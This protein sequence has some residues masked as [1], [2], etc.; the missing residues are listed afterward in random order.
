[1]PYREA[2]DMKEPSNV[3]PYVRRVLLAVIA[4]S[5]GAGF[6]VGTRAT[7]AYVEAHPRPCHDTVETINM[8][9]EKISCEHPDHVLSRRDSLV[10]CT[11]RGHAP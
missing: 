2:P 4:V 1:M 9:G 5:A 6:V 7:C 10:W 8:G 3:W 11:C